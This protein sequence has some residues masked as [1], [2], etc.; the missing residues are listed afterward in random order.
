[1]NAD[2]SSNRL[3]RTKRRRR[4]LCRVMGQLYTAFEKRQMRPDR[5]GE[6]GRLKSLGGICDRNAVPNGIVRMEKI[7]IK[8]FQIPLYG[9][10][11]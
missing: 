6:Q 5:I 7:T 8:S 2:I 4:A 1:M 9:Y 3:S 10:F 11:R